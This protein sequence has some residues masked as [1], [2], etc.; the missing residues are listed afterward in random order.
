MSVLEGI[1]A[2]TTAVIRVSEGLAKT[3]RMLRDGSLTVA[4]YIA[5][6]SLEGLVFTVNVGTL[7]GPITFNGGGLVA[8]EFDLHVAVPSGVYII[9]LELTIAFEAYGTTSIMECCM[10]S[11]SG[12]VVGT[13]NTAVTP[14][15]SNVSTGKT[16]ACT[17]KYVGDAGTAFT[18]NVKEI[19][20][21]GQQ[22]VVTLATVTD[23]REGLP[24]VNRW[25]AKDSGALDVVG[26]SQQLGIFAS[27]QAGAGFICLKYAELPV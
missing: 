9:P 22:K 8:T 17:C 7:T 2:Q 10:V 26:P 1:A 6:L 5:A 15:S 11:G 13:T 24:Y 23:I 20:R 21:T 4:D 3:V 19:W 18:T 14:Q 25:F 27:A 12:S 16:S